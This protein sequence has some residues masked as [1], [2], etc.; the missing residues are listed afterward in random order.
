PLLTK[1]EKNYLQKLKESSQGV[2]ALIDYTHFKGTGL[3]PKERYRGQGWGLLQVLQMMAESQTKE[4]TVT[5]F[6]SSAK[7]VLAKRVRNAP[8]SRKEERW[9]NGWYKRLE[10][11]SSITL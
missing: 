3:S 10:T 4:A 8:L 5:T 11:Y 2:Y 9:I 1:Q 6:V 7:K